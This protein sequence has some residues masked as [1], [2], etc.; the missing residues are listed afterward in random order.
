MSLREQFECWYVIT[1]HTWAVFAVLMA[2]MC[3]T[4]PDHNAL[5]GNGRKCTYV[6][7]RLSSMQL[8]KYKGDRTP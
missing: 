3:P 7:V 4:M 8:S 5:S 1:L 2:N 6:S